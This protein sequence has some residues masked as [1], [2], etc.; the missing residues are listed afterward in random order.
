MATLQVEE[1][2]SDLP[3]VETIWRSAHEQET[4]FVSMAQTH[5]GMVVTRLEG[6]ITLTVRGPETKATSAIAPA[7]SEHFGIL[8][9]YNS[10]MPH[11]PA[12]AVMDRQ[13]MVLPD[14][15]SRS[16]WLQG[17]AWEFPNFDN[18][19]TFI[20]RL[21]R[22]GLLV[23]EPV[24]EAALHGHKHDLSLRSLQ[25]RFLQATGLTHGTLYQIERARYA[26]SLLLRGT[27]ILDTIE[28]AGY[29][30][31][32][33]LTRSLKQYIGHTPAQLVRSAVEKPLS[34]LY[35][36]TLFG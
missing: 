16:F 36:T 3:F 8:F 9:K 5:W 27:S 19:D 29:F 33:H 31:Q 10:F 35:K 2:P 7:N 30:D 13:D 26:T 32:P 23:R 18:A 14:A 6:K 34:F 22:Q 25:R 4:P 28:Q 15:S 1:R 20:E 12:K 24:V 17:S 21:V 11:L